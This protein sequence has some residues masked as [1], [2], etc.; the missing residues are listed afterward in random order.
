MDE[1]MMLEACDSTPNP[2]AM[3]SVL[4]ACAGLAAL[5]YGKLVHGYV[6]RRGY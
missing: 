5:E 2:V 1:L 3:V 6:L 4:Q